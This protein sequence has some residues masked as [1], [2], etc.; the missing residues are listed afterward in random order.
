MVIHSK[1][2]VAGL[3]ADH[4]TLRISDRPFAVVTAMVS[5]DEPAERAVT[6]SPFGSGQVRGKVVGVGEP[7]T[8]VYVGE[9]LETGFQLPPALRT[10]PFFCVAAKSVP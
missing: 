10:R 6:E 1:D 8:G 9:P 7:G 5:F 3:E 4:S 2:M